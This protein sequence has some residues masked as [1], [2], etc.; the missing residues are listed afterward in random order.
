[1]IIDCHAHVFQNWDGLCGH[2][3]RDVRMKYLQR[4]LAYRA[5]KAFR[6]RDG[7][8]ADDLA[9]LEP[10]KSG[11]SGLR[12]LDIRV[13]PF[14]RVEF[15]ADGEDYFVQYMPV[16]MQTIESS[17]EYMLAQMTYAGVDH[18][19]LQAGGIYG[20]M[21]PY[22]AFAQQQYPQKFTSLMSVEGSDPGSAACLAEIDEAA[23]LGLKGIY[24]NYDAFARHEFAWQPDD[25]KLVP[26]WERIDGHNLIVCAE[27]NGAP[28]HDKAG[29]LKTMMALARVFEHFPRLRCHL[30][31]GIPVRHFSAGDRWDLTDELVAL[32]KRD[33]LFMEIVFPIT[34]A[35]RWDY[36]YV[37]AQPLI[38]DARDRFG[39][40]K[41]MWGSDMPNVERFCTYTQS[42]TYLTR[43]CSF[44]S[45]ADMDKVLGGNAAAL[46][47]IDA[48]SC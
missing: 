31:M 46:Y 36:P 4:G 28:T 34:W 11:W 27:V 48:T 25:P 20:A 32:Y 15:T 40:E 3:S 1:M 30:A 9:L 6:T 23:A 33:T 10:G 13:G 2:P 21:T 43:Y 8:P 12:D 26:F 38:R 44:L 24:F 29:Y 37:E 42:L 14:G 45:G 7:K 22:N 39:A 19:I 17:P 35:G 47:G 5:A 18:T 16:S 41:L